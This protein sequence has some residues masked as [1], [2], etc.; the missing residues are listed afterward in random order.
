VSL[1]GPTWACLDA[2]IRCAGDGASRRTHGQTMARAR[3]ERFK[4]RVW[5]DRAIV[6]VGAETP[7]AHCSLPIPLHRA[8]PCTVLGLYYAGRRLR[9][10]D[11]QTSLLPWHRRVRPG[12]IL[13]ANGIPGV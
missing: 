13:E 7:V 4:V 11:E 12:C 10:A 1:V 3:G 5:A 6:R 2:A 9:P 8:S